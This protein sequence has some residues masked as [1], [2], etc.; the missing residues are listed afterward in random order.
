MP[1]AT[2]PLAFAA[3]PV[4]L[5]IVG[6]AHAGGLDRNGCPTEIDTGRHHRRRTVKANADVKTP[7]RKSPG[8]IRRRRIPSNYTMIGYFIAF[9]AMQAGLKTG[10]R[11]SGS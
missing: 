6:H 7:A 10:G 11:A 8:N 1:R 3:M 9:E 4:S 2:V 5:G